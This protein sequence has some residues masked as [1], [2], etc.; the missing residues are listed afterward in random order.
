MQADD[1]RTAN[2]VPAD[3]SGTNRAE[4][5]DVSPT[6]ELAGR[7]TG[8]SVGA[9]VQPAGGVAFRVWAPAHREVAVVL[10]G[11]SGAAVVERPLRAEAGGY[12]SSIVDEAAP[13]VLYRFRLSGAR[14]L[15]PDP[16]SRFQPAG[17]N[18]PSQV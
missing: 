12:F 15:L 2:G 5:T 7:V 9:E 13:G 18:G 14:E 11:A 8:G 17:P 1:G 10:E 4:P 16:A 6:E 3:E